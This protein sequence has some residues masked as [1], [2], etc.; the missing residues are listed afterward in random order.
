MVGL[1]LPVLPFRAH[2]E[3]A[4]SSSAISS[5]DYY[6]Y[7]SYYCYCIAGQIQGLSG[8]CPGSDDN[9]SLF[10]V[11][12]N[13]AAIQ[14]FCDNL[15]LVLQSQTNLIKHHEW[16]DRKSE[17]QTDDDGCDPGLQQR[18]CATTI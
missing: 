12:Q 3:S 18:L 11:S 5:T 16:R 14:R 8:G 10:V 4:L 2:L 9:D 7:Y 15:F 6:Y 1:G 17:T 13:I